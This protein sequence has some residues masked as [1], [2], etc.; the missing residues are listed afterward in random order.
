MKF[1]GE[2]CEGQLIQPTFIT[3]YPIE[4]SPLIKNIENMRGWWKG[5]SYCNGKEICILSLNLM[6]QLTK[7]LDLKIN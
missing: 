6:I 4:M 1:F 2:K 5:L 3:D 7:E